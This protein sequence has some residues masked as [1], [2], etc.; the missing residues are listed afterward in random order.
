MDPNMN[1]FADRGL[2]KVLQPVTWVSYVFFTGKFEVSEFYIN[3]W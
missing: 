2:P 1:S 3:A